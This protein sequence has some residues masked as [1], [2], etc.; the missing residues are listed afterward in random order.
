[1]LKRLLLIR[2]PSFAQQ[3]VEIEHLMGRFIHDLP[4]EMVFDRRWRVADFEPLSPATVN[5]IEH[6]LERPQ[7]ADEPK[8]CAVVELSLTR[9]LDNRLHGRGAALSIALLEKFLRQF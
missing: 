6:P 8:A 4:R 9:C 2:D 7:A 3:D 5:V 1:M